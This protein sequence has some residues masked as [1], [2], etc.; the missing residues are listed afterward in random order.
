MVSFPIVLYLSKVYPSSRFLPIGELLKRKKI[1]IISV[2]L[3]AQVNYNKCMKF[4]MWIV[5][6]WLEKFDPQPRITRGEMVI[7]GVRY[8]SDGIELKEDLLY[9]G[10]AVDFIPTRK[11]GVICANGEDLILL[12]LEDVYTAFN[13][14]QQMLEYYNE[15]EMGIMR[16]IDEGSS[17]TEILEMTRPVFDTTILVTDASHTM[18]G[19]AHAPDE[20]PHFQYENGVLSTEDIIRL[21][22]ILQQYTDLREAY[23]V[24][25]GSHFLS[26]I[27]NFH[28]KSG[29]LIGWFVAME[30]GEEKQKSRLQTTEVFCRLLDFW[31]RINESALLFSPQSELF[32]SILDGKE[33][34]PSVISFKKEGIG[35]EGDPEMQLFVV[36]S[37]TSN[38]LDIQFLQK[39][40]SSSFSAV[41]CFRYASDILII[42][43]YNKIHKDLFLPQLSAALKK[44]KTYCGGSYFFRNLRDLAAYY[45]QAQLALK[46]GAETPGTI[47]FCEDYALEYIR[48]QI[49]ENISIPIQSPLLD[50]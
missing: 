37:G 7:K 10:H 47:S 35:W 15:W 12:D 39:A 24:D 8:F 30:A 42:V 11:N 43:N 19:I 48:Q 32:L 4:S 5:N 33:T 3:F 20:R 23:V 28:S 31:F 16:A 26:I 9:V 6:D 13:A 40:L 44:R 27:R 50:T 34:D 22:V 45:R 36:D 25:D 14:I 18:L 38:P 17:L 29:E 21:N 49:N 46:Y 1:L 41:Y 2:V